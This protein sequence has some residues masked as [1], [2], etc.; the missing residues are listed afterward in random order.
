MAEKNRTEIGSVNWFDLTVEDAEMIRDF[1]SDVIGW[2][3]ENVPMGKY[4]DYSMKSPESGKIAAGICHAR[5]FNQD[6]PPQ[7]LIYITVKN[8]DESIKKCTNSGGK[9]ISG[10]RKLGESA[11]YCVIQDPAGAVCALYEEI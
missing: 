6:L 3:P 7:W 2:V 4:N 8:V 11:K 1:Y 9:V 10:P 5:G